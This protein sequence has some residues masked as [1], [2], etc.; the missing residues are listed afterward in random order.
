MARIKSVV[1]VEEMVHNTVET[2]VKDATVMYPNFLETAPLFVTYYSISSYQSTF[3]ESFEN[4][5]EVAGEESPNKFHRIQGFPL[6][7]IDLSDFSLNQSDDGWS[8]EVQSSAIVLPDTTIPLPDDLFEIEFN[9]KKYLFQVTNVTPD[10]I[11]NNC[12][13]RISFRLGQY[14]KDEVERQTVENF[15]IDYNL[16]GRQKNTLIKLD[17]NNHIINIKDKYD[18]LLDTYKSNYFDKYLSSFV[19]K[20]L[21]LLDQYLNYFIINNDIS[22][23]FIE[24]RNSTIISP[25]L[26]KYIDLG[27]YSRSLYKLI[28]DNN[29]LPLVK[30]SYN[31]HQ[32]KNGY[33]KFQFFHFTQN[34]AY[35]VKYTEPKDNS[36]VIGLDFSFLAS[37]YPI[38][39][40]NLEFL[41]L[42]ASIFLNL[43][44]KG[45][46]TQKVMYDRSIGLQLENEELLNKI[47]DQIPLLE[48]RHPRFPE[49]VLG[50][51]LNNYH[52]IPLI[53]NALREIYHF[54]VRT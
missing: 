36:S 4:Y 11:G 14:R 16:I 17:Y 18:I 51:Q 46:L 37:Q 45:K 1:S 29:F 34:K 40:P 21:R 32:E 13:Y 2:F 54:L 49:D 3:D 44:D 28:E 52:A 38:T 47:L 8:S 42:Y 48:A 23:P 27:N 50:V 22:K 30:K 19:F 53:L 10:N 39:D 26:M 41:R 33:G 43:D 12:F 24:F 35:F 15:K 9:S 31:I 20:D 5:N 6:Y 25:D 7:S